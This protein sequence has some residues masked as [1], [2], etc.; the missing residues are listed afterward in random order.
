MPTVQTRTYTQE[1]KK[2]KNHTKKIRQPNK[3]KEKEKP[4]SRQQP[5]NP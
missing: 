4:N 1:R 2:E 3:K 5:D